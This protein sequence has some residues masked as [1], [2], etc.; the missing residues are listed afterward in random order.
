M[1][2]SI[3]IFLFLAFILQSFTSF[4]TPLVFAKEVKQKQAKPVKKTQL[5]QVKKQKPQSNKICASNLEQTTYQIWLDYYEAQ[6]QGKQLPLPTLN[7]PDTVAAKEA[8]RVRAIWQQAQ[9]LAQL[10]VQPDEPPQPHYQNIDGL[11]SSHIAGSLKSAGYNNVMKPSRSSYTE[12]VSNSIN[13]ATDKANNDNSVTAKSTIKPTVELNSA[14]YEYDKEGNLS[15]ATLPNGVITTYIYNALNR[16][17]NIKVEKAGTILA[18]YDYTRGPTGNILSVKELNGRTV[19]Y[20]YDDIY[21]L[22]SETISGS[23]NPNSNGTIRYTYDAVGNRLQRNSLV[24]AVPVQQLS[25][26]NNDRLTT[27]TY[28]ANGNTKSSG[29]R[30]YTYDVG[31]HITKVTDSASNLKLL[32]LYDA[33]GNRVS[34]TVGI[35]NNSGIYITDPVTTQYL[36]DDDNP[37]GYPQVVEEI[38]NGK[39]VRQYTYD[40][41]GIISQRQLINSQWVNSFYIKDGHG[42]IRMLTDAN[43]NIT[44][45]FDYD[46]FGVLINRTGNTPNNYLYLGEQFDPDLGFYYLRARY[47][48]PSTGRFLTMDQFEGDIFNPQSLHKYVYA[49]NDPVNKI[50]PSGNMSLTESS[51]AQGLANRLRATFGRLYLRAVRALPNRIRVSIVFRGAHS[52]FGGQIRESAKCVDCTKRYAQ[53]EGL[54]MDPS[55]NRGGPGI[56]EVTRGRPTIK[57]HYAVRN[58]DGT[59]TDPSIR[60][61]I[62][63]EKGLNHP[64]YRDIIR[65]IA[66]DLLKVDTFSPSSYKVLAEILIELLIL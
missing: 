40:T 20:S 29:N 15:R 34:K 65:D 53:L 62:L 59:I 51:I 56:F 28:D 1:R 44:D 36:I 14:I 5:Q 43:G 2:R 60:Q 12:I 11:A 6:K 49:Q 9:L 16:L 7:I 35:T 37:T 17:T 33:D 64:I 66:D 38:E 21:R 58:N 45:T 26:D 25:Y 63:D 3:P 31:N 8:S 13:S 46:A 50:D 24:G 27:D 32:Y 22:T 57:S 30:D 18:S 55:K 41:H 4:S 61:N 54:P 23:T 19:N 47:L 42:S 39:A 48:N 52:R 10:E